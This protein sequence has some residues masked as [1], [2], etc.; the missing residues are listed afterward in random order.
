MN[1]HEAAAV[2]IHAH[3]LPY[4]SV[5]KWRA[6]DKHH[7]PKLVRDAEGYELHFSDGGVA[8]PLP[9]SL[10]GAE[11]RLPYME[12]TG[13]RTQIVSA[14]PFVQFYAYPRATGQNFIRI[15]NDDLLEYAG[16]LPA[17]LGVLASLPMRNV[18]DAVMEAKR[19]SSEPLV[20]G[21]AVGS[22]VN[23]SY[24][25]EPQFQPLWEYLASVDLP[26]HV[27]PLNVAGNERMAKHFGRNLVG[28]P[29]DTT[30]AIASLI[31]TGSMTRI[32]R[33][34]VCVSH[35]GGF[36]PYQVGRWDQGWRNR[37]ES[38]EQLSE[39]PSDVLRRFYFD[40]ILH[41]DVALDYLGRKIGWS[42][43]LI[44]TDF[45]FAMGEDRP[46]AQ[47]T[48]RLPSAVQISQVLYGNSERFLRAV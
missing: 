21:V 8:G 39:L 3:L 26:L 20:R 12:N 31:F 14:P 15:L 19:L 30:L 38:R 40:S 16:D 10:F 33:L 2:D 24:L 45:P 22:N 27:H 9:A 23:G 41:D 34:R 47:V 4:Q 6:A 13:V 11:E 42:Q 7:A 25:G 29:L 32:P 35:G 46:A 18:Q 44:G 43:I 37:R 36:A 17:K 1:L 5:A 48:R 28:N